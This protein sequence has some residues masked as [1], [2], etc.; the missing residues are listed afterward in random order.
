[1]DEVE[2]LWVIGIAIIASPGRSDGKLVELRAKG[3]TTLV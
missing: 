3:V 2:V 1:M